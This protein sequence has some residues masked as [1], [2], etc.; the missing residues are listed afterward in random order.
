V[1]NRISRLAFGT[2]KYDPPTGGQVEIEPHFEKLINL[3]STADSASSQFAN[4]NSVGQ[5][6]ICIIPGIKPTAEV[7]HEEARSSNFHCD[8]RG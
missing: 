6:W 7:C 8:D 5:Q 4:F 2:A 1:K 3:L